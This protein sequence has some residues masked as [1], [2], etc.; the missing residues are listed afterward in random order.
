MQIF[1]G[2]VGVIK[3]PRCAEL[4]IGYQSTRNHR[5]A[6]LYFDPITEE[7]QSGENKRIN[8]V[9]VLSE[10]MEKTDDDLKRFKFK[11]LLRNLD[12]IRDQHATLARSFD[13]KG[14]VLDN[15]NPWRIADRTL[16]AGANMA[17]V[18]MIIDHPRVQKA[19]D[20]YYSLGH[21]EF[22]ELFLRGEAML[23]L[24]RLE[25]TLYAGGEGLLGLIDEVYWTIE[26]RVLSEAIS[27]HM[28]A[29]LMRDALNQNPILI[30]C[31][32]S[33][34][35]RRNASSKLI[36]FEKYSASYKRG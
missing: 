33:N 21:G 30:N 28:E 3:L 14:G 34:L 5:W 6:V 17:G 4:V 27:H 24:D 13:G 15:D 19:L 12:D 26:R 2:M 7:I 35:G 1:F 29:E 16:D 25:S 22:K 31:G 36:Q 23:M 20:A 8:V 11:K 32:R 9:K 10:A 18:K